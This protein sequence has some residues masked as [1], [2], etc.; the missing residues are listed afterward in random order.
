MNLRTAFVVA[1]FAVAGNAA[2]LS[3]EHGTLVAGKPV[4]LSVKLAAGSDLPTGVQFDLE[5]DA[6]ALDVSV[7]AGPAAT[8]SG[9]SV[10]TSIIQAGKQRVLIIGVNRNSISDGVVA[11]LHVSF[12]GQEGGKTFPIRITV[13]SGTN[14][15]A[16]SVTVSGKDGSVKIESR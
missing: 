14:G 9:K 8:Q 13:P 5:Y 16:E 2:E 11:V 1:M 7:E 15:K 6:A 3:I 12:K 4:A 10:S